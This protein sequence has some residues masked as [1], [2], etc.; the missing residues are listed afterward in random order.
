MTILET[1]SGSKL[2]A[3]LLGWMFSHPD[4][5]YYVRQLTGILKEDSTNLSRELA[6]LERAGILIC[7]AEGRQKYY[8]ANRKS[9]VFNEL[10]GLIVKTT[11]IGDGLRAILAPAAKQIQLAFI[12]GSFAAGDENKSS[13]IDLMVIGDIPPEKLTVLLDEA[14]NRLGREINPALYTAT[15]FHRKLN[16]GHHFL[17]AVVKGEKIFLIGGEDELGRLAG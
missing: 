2:R 17:T 1:I 13:D 14:E 12:F 6:R 5:R 15:E 9:Q 3:K 16:E 7:I 4:E 11:G 8:Q 10:H